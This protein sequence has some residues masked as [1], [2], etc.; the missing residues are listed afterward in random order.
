MSERVSTAG[1]SL[2]YAVESSAGQRPTTGY[3][4]IPEIKSMPSFN[5]SPNT[6]RPPSSGSCKAAH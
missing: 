3:K 5:P 1:M 4:K 2:Q 6:I